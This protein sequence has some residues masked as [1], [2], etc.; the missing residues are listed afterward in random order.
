MPG[1]GSYGSAGKWVHDRAHHI[2]SKNPDMDKGQAYAIATQQGHKLGK[3]NKGHRTAEGVAVAKQ[4]Y[5]GSRD[6]YKKTAAM[7]MSDEFIKI[8]E[9]GKKR[10]V[11]GDIAAQAAAGI[12]GGALS[13]VG[14][15]IARDRIRRTAVQ[16]FNSALNRLHDS[17]LAGKPGDYIVSAFNSVAREAKGLARNA[18]LKSALTNAAIVPASLLLSQGVARGIDKLR[19]GEKTIKG[20]TPGAVAQRKGHL[21]P[22][23]VGS[24]LG[25]LAGAGIDTL[26]RNRLPD[27]VTSHVLGGVGA[28]GGLLYALRRDSKKRG[29]IRPAEKTAAMGEDLRIKGPAGIRRPP[30]PTE[31][32]KAMAYS[33]FKKAKKVGSYG[34]V[35][36]PTPII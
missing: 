19:G 22:I 16:G 7:A 10:S 4:K 35:K 31:G 3:S 28:L 21:A 1:R 23:L 12:S 24:S 14:H 26:I 34:N 13:G 36:P 17:N 9:E 27:P 2:M 5:S 18:A 25:S 15:M 33:N 11:A 32:S 29:R 30:F 6:M 20:V 8:A